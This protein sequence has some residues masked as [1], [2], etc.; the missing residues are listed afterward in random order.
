[1]ALIWLEHVDAQF[2]AALPSIET[3]PHGLNYYKQAVKVEPK[4]LLNAKD[5][6]RAQLFSSRFTLSTLRGNFF[7]L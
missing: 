6:E 5:I 1:M 3:S 2:F 7:S 4:E